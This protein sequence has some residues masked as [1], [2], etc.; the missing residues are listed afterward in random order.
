MC[1]GDISRPRPYTLPQASLLPSPQPALVIADRC[2]FGLRICSGMQVGSLRGHGQKS[3]GG[4][5]LKS[6]GRT[7]RSSLHPPPHGAPPLLAA[8][9]LSTLGS[10]WP[11]GCLL[12]LVPLPGSSH[13]PPPVPSSSRWS[14]AVV[15]ATWQGQRPLGWTLPEL[16]DCQQGMSP[17]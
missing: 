16:C 6:C 11:R 15:R 3:C 4:L 12:T 10:P 7:A 14:C 9:A 5:P 17:L 13:P 1:L 8:G 2:F